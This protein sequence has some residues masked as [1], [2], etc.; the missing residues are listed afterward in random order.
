[1]R[2]PRLYIDQSLSGGNSATIQAAPFLH[3]RDVLRMKAGQT[4]HL[5]NGDGCDYVAVIQEVGKRDLRVD[6]EQIIHLQ[7]ESPLCTH[8][9]A[10]LC[11]GDRFDLCLQKSTELG[12]NEITPLYTSRTNLLYKS[13]QLTNKKR[14]WQR[15][16]E[17]ACEQSGRAQI[18]M[19]HEPVTLKE[20]SDSYAFS[21][22]KILFDHCGTSLHDNAQSCEK[23]ACAIGPEGGFTPEELCMAKQHGF[24]IYRMG[25]RTLRAETA[26][27]AA[28]SLLQYQFGDF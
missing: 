3:V 13:Q 22:R 24:E 21:G 10:A 1:M 25:N 26:A 4:L 8:L 17:N 11:K 5:F 14:H 28:L 19:L 15:V 27:I 12:V 7:N 20:W 9:L 16:I 23:I 6:I 18:P 2:I